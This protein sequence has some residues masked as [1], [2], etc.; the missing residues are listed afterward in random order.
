MP[1]Q[2]GQALNIGK[3]N[4]QQDRVGVF[5]NGSGTA[6]MLVV[7]DGMG[8]IPNGDQAAQI[9]VDTAERAFNKSKIKNPESFLED[10]CSQAHEAINRIETNNAAA[11]GTTCVLLY[12]DKRR[13]YWAHI[14]DSRLY[15]FR[16]NYLIN[17]TQ[18]HSVRQLM[19]QRGLI[20]TASEEA[21]ATQNQLYKRLGGRQEPVPDIYSSELERGD[22]F[23]LCSDGF[24]QSVDTHCIP[25]ILNH[26]PLERDG[27]EC[28]VDIALKNGGDNCDNISVALARWTHSQSFFFRNLSKLLYGS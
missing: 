26:H 24:W 15:H 25:E 27:A 12:I 4:E 13:A 2:F 9:V 3:R 7:A 19:I 1:W 11:P 28:L 8:G 10:I 20:D 17:Q 18:D 22:M 23:L 21:S 5:H 6:H 16:Q 14:G